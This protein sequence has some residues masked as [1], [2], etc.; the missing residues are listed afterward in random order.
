MP[1]Q[2]EVE[3]IF[4]N[5]LTGGSPKI[6]GLEEEEPDVTKTIGN[7]IHFYGEITPENTLEFV[8][9]FRKLEIH[10]LKQKADLIGYVP[11]IRVHIMS[12]GGDMFSG[13]TLKNVLEKSRVKVVTIAQ[14]A[15]CSAA[16]FMFLGGNERLM[17]ENAYLLIHQ[18]STE[19]WGKYH[20]LK[21]E[22]KSCDKFMTS[23]KKMYMNKTKI[24]EKKFKKLMKK[25][26]Y[27]SASKCLKYEIAH[28]ID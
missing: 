8:E 18:L 5:I 17:G 16:T 27:L 12:E 4:E 11:K 2:K 23:L 3:K 22:M 21:S 9:Q 14:G 25:D 24:P 26:L 6:P 15:C 7:E 20:E 13:F 10:L 19:I 1:S 28:G